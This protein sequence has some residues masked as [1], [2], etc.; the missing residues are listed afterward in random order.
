MY[1]LAT[2]AHYM[3]SCEISSLSPAAKLGV[4]IRAVA[5]QCLSTTAAVGLSMWKSTLTATL[6][7][8]FKAIKR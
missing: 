7:Y 1:S 8:L 3:L 5:V 2:L 4:V 6:C